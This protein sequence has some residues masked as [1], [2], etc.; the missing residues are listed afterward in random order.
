MVRFLLL[1]M[2]AL[3]LA[4]TIPA[5]TQRFGGPQGPGGGYGG[6]GPPGPRDFYG[7]KGSN[8]GGPPRGYGEGPGL[9]GI[10]GSPVRVQMSHC[11]SGK[12]FD[13][14]SGKCRTVIV[15]KN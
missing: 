1:A 12:Y 9:P 3:L 10:V 13:H 5:D 15:E 6:N 7:P 8:E 14:R 11:P 4:L 2:L